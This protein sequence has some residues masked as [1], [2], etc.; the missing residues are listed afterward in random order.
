[1][2]NSKNKKAIKILDLGVDE[3]MRRK[4]GIQYKIKLKQNLAIGIG[5]HDWHRCD[6]HRSDNNKYNNKKERERERERQEWAKDNKD[7]LER[8]GKFVFTRQINW[9]KSKKKRDYTW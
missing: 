5:G 7:G 1:M 2:R 3:R 8:E 4:N 9:V 6:C